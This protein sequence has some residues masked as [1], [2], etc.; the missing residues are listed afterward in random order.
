MGHGVS[1]DTNIVIVSKL[2]LVLEILC[3]NYQHGSVG[4]EVNFL[5][6]IGMTGFERLQRQPPFRINSCRSK[7]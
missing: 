5:Q 7:A 3:A 6:K 2:S 4:A 1:L